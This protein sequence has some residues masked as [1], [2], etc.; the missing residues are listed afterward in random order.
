MKENSARS[1]PQVMLTL[2]REHIQY[3][4]LKY[5]VP[6]LEA[7]EREGLTG[8]GNLVYGLV[9]HRLQP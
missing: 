2:H 9:P 1:L 8:L 5:F 6:K 3:K 4:L 7:L